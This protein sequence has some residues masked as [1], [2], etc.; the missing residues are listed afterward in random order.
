MAPER[1]VM[2]GM[3]LSSTLLRTRGSRLNPG[4][5]IPLRWIWFATDSGPRFVVSTQNFANMID[6]MTITEK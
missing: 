1:M 6:P 3:Y 2:V 4:I 5:C